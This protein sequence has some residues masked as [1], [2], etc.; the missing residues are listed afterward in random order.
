MDGE[1]LDN[2]FPFGYSQWSA[3]SVWKLNTA[4]V[5][6]AALYMPAIAPVKKRAPEPDVAPVQYW[7]PPG[8]NCWAG[9]VSGFL[10]GRVRVVREE[11]D[12][13]HSLCAANA[14]SRAAA[15]VA[16]WCAVGGNRNRGNLQRLLYAPG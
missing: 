10:G 15:A 1:L 5:K 12:S 13:A 11:H 4:Y 7:T 2:D 6:R 9:D 16:S 8:H 14:A 3:E